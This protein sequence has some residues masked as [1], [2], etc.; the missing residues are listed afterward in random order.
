VLE[1]LTAGNNKF[2][3]LEL[4]IWPFLSVTSKSC[5]LG[6]TLRNYEICVHG[7]SVCG[8]TTKTRILTWLITVNG[9]CTQIF[10]LCAG[11]KPGPLSAIPQWRS[12]WDQFNSSDTVVNVPHL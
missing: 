7:K 6:I 12:L 11:L 2:T 9:K 3:E 4:L 8:R 1:L 10:N 5:V